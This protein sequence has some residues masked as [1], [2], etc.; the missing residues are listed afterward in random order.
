[1]AKRKAIIMKK[2]LFLICVII[3]VAAVY[4]PS[5]DRQ[6]ITVVVKSLSA[7]Q[8]FRAFGKAVDGLCAW[9]TAKGFDRE[10][11]FKKTNNDKLVSVVKEKYGELIAEVCR[12]KDFPD[13][14]LVVAVIIIESSGNPNAHNRHQEGDGWGLMG[15][16]EKTAAAQGVSFDKILNPYWNLVAGIG[17]LA[18]QFK[19]Y[20]K[21]SARAI[22][23]YNGLAKAAAPEK[24]EYYLKVQ[25]LLEVAKANEKVDTAKSLNAVVQADPDAE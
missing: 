5:K 6:Q 10:T 21:G 25:A 16:K 18:D 23:A 14:D 22:D 3:C 1:M 20:G 13:T 9:F 2:V 12:E 15:V 19:K 4:M 11:Y 8:G 24:T 17:Y 7:K